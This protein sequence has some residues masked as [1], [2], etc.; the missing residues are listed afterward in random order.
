MI[1][2]FVK[3]E[4]FVTCFFPSQYNVYLTVHSFFSPLFSSF[5]PFGVSSCPVP[6]FLLLPFFVLPLSPPSPPLGFE[7][8]FLF[9]YSFPFPLLLFFLVLLPLNKL[10]ILFHVLFMS[11]TLPL[12]YLISYTFQG[13]RF[14]PCVPF[15]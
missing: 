10:L 7:H 6:Y 15:F 13:I 14:N 9:S 11:A 3:N 5:C 4:Q 1:N 8:F 2:F 12:C